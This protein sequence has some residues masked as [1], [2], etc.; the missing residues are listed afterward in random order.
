MQQAW[1]CMLCGD[2]TNVNNIIFEN[3]CVVLYVWIFFC[4]YWGDGNRRKVCLIHVH[5]E[6]VFSDVHAF[7][8]EKFGQRKQKHR[9]VRM[10]VPDSVRV[11]YAAVR[12]HGYFEKQP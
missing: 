8:P 5:H 10:S 3:A 11:V 6:I 9:R 12:M 7:V 1:A 4:T 2:T